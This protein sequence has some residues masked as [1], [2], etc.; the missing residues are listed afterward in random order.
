MVILMTYPEDILEKH[1]NII[2]DFL[3]YSLSD[4]KNEVR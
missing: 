3:T 2:E 4:A 1:I